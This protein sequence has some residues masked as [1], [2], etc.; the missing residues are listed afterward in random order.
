[1]M[2]DCKECGNRVSNQANTCPQCGAP[3]KSA[4]LA[5]RGH[6]ML[7]IVVM[8]AGVALYMVSPSPNWTVVGGVMMV[9]GLIAALL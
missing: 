5:V 6:Q 3:I 8:I 2:I 4:N 9:G 1:M 7:A